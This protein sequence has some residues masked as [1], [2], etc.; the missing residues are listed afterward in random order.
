MDRLTNV[1][2]RLEDMP[3]EEFAKQVLI[4]I[5]TKY[6]FS[7]LVIG[8]PTCLVKSDWNRLY[9]DLLKL[10]VPDDI[11]MDEANRLAKFIAKKALT[12]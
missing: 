1:L 2:Q 3:R 10:G 7:K 6:E 5:G 4:S 9:P 8:G 12:Y 11:T